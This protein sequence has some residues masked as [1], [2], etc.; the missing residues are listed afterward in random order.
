MLQ[1]VEDERQLARRGL[2]ARGHVDVVGAELDAELPHLAADVLVEALD[3]VGD[4]LARQD[5]EVLVEP[6]GDAARGA[7]EVGRRFERHDALE[8]GVDE[9][10][11]PEVEAVL[12]AIEERAR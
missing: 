9:V 3:L 7:F 2:E 4:G 5:A 12:H 10:A 6:E 1:R 8:L 11:Q